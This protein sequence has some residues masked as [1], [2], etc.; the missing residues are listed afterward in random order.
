M[1]VVYRWIIKP[2][3]MS[4]KKITFRQL[5][6]QLAPILF[7]PLLVTAL[8]GMGYRLGRNWFNLPKEKVHFLLDIHQGTYWGEQLMPIYILLEGLALIFMVVTGI[9][10]FWKSLKVFKKP[11]AQSD[12]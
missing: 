5:H 6:R 1:L 3:K 2:L 9:V 8:S 10:I 7:L 11:K 4:S 12:R